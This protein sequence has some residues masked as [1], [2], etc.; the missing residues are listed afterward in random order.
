M[1]LPDREVSKSQRKGSL[2]KFWK[3]TPAARGQNSDSNA[4][5]LPPEIWL[6]II[7]CISDHELEPLSR[8]SRHLRSMALPLYFRSQ[9]IFP[10]LETFAFRWQNKSLE[11]AGY[12]HR[13]LQRL[14]FLSSERISPC[15]QNILISPYPPSYNRR[16]RVHHSPVDAVMWRLLS[17]LPQFQNLRRL[18]LH[19]PFCN[20]ALLSVLE[21]LHLDSFELEVMP[22]ALLS[23]PIPARK[24]F[25]FNRSESPNQA[26]PPAEL[27]LNFLSPESI[28]RMVAGPTGTDTLTRALLSPPCGFPSLKFLDLSLRFAASPDFLAALAACRNLTSIRLRSSV[29]DAPPA[30]LLPILHQLGHT[31]E[32]LELSVT[33]VP[34][35]LLETI[36]DIFPVLSTLSINT[37]LDAFHPGAV[38]RH[39][40]PVPSPLYATLALPSGM[41]LTVLRLGLQLAGTASV[42]ASEQIR[43]SACTAVQAFPVDYDPTSWMRWSVEESWYCV[44]WTRSAADAEHEV[45]SAQDGTL[46]IEYKEYCVEGFERGTR[47]SSSTL[48]ESAERMAM[49]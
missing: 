42:S 33:I 16:H 6:D 19:F 20:D 23:I 24:E 37:H 40:L 13:S 48:K 10:F 7:A 25:I 43:E 1:T 11:L 31:I 29:M 35:W 44:E 21:P 28:E 17:L 8:V 30:Y 34:V 18:I 22:T 15:V 47:I 2:L 12:Q 4:L 9:H 3:K 46:R 45:A 26:F 27:S 5:V 49:V 36:R 14:G 32:D 38:M 39:S 41:R